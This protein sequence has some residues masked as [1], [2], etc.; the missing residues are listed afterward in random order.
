MTLSCAASGETL[1]GKFGLPGQVPAG[2]DA[3]GQA[4]E[5]HVQQQGAAL[6]WTCGVVGEP[7]V[8]FCA[9]GI[10]DGVLP[11]PARPCSPT[12]SSRAS[13]SRASSV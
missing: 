4:E 12:V 10:G 2:P 11:A 6:R 7:G 5:E 13:V 8:D 9:A 1:L 3:V